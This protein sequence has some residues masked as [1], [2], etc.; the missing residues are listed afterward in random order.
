MKKENLISGALLSLVLG[1]CLLGMGSES[2]ATT[3]SISPKPGFA[4][5]YT[6]TV[7]T[8]AVGPCSVYRVVLSSGAAS[9]YVALFDSAT[10]SGL[11]AAT[12]NST[13]KT[14]LLFN[15]TTANTTIQFDPPLEFYN[16]LMVGDLAVTGQS[17][18]EYDLGRSGGQ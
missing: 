12:I 4:L 11:T 8:V 14:R 9:E 16:G 13:L 1:V 18:I 10:A 17:L 7:S 6:T 3:A 5:N 15:S 2:E